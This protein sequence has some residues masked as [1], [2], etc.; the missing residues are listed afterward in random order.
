MRTRRAA[1][2]WTGLPRA[3]IAVYRFVKVPGVGNHGMSGLVPRRER[4]ANRR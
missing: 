1:L 4:A 2:T 3:G